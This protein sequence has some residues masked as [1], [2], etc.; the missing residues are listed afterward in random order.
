MPIKSFV[1]TKIFNRL[2]NARAKFRIFDFETAKIAFKIQICAVKIF[3]LFLYFSNMA[4]RDRSQCLNKMMLV[5]IG[6]HVV[7]VFDTFTGDY[8]LKKRQLYSKSLVFLCLFL[9]TSNEN[10]ELMVIDLFIRD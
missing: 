9:G 3:N 6:L 2:K 10:P 5:Q 4:E 1:I 8:R 7:H